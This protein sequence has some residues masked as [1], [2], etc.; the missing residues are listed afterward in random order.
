MKKIVISFGVVVTAVFIALVIAPVLAEKKEITLGA[1]LNPAERTVMDAVA[2]TTT[3]SAFNVA[4]FQFI[5]WTVATDAVSGTLKIACSMQDTEPTFSAATSTSNRWDYVD[6]TDLAT[7]SS[8]DGATGLPMTNVSNVR[9]FAIE[10][11][12][13]RWCTAILSPWTAGT[14]TVKLLPVTNF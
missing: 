1:R 3:G 2:A 7:D 14:T 12:P 6:V 8:I 11:S 4:D 5:G 13:F 10:N 9:Q